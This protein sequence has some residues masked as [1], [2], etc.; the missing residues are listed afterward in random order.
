MN[1]LYLGKKK[2]I[3]RLVDTLILARDKFPG[4]PVSLRR[5]L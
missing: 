2:L 4:S 5:S 3:T 1:C